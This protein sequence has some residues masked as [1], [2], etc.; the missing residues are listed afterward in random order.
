MCKCRK[1]IEITKTR[2]KKA[3]KITVGKPIQTTLDLSLSGKR[4]KRTG[5][6]RDPIM[7]T[8]KDWSDLM[9]GQNCA[10]QVEKLIRGQG[11]Q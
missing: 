4:G 6:L 5:L 10:P 7:F 11:L 9:P 3:D 1:H 2:M 8:L